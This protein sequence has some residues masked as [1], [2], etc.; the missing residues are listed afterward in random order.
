[1]ATKIITAWIDGTV[2]EIEVED[3]ISPEQNLSYEDRL[4]ELEDKPIITDGNFLVGNG[5]DEM[6]EITPEE[7]LSHINGANVFPITTAEYTALEQAQATNANT[8][9]MLTDIVEETPTQV[10]II[11]STDTEDLTEKLQTLQIHKLTEEQYQQKVESGSVEDNALYL[12][13]DEEIDLTPY[14]TIEYVNE[15]VEEVSTNIATAL[16]KS[17]VQIITW[18]DD[19]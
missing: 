16:Q 4:I 11:T 8:L 19:D 1:M 18:E 17:Q 9:Y 6:E 2:Q 5:T 3:I 15:Y 12:T 14:A 10:Q 7:V 13:P